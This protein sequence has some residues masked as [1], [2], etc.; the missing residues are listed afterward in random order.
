MNTVFYN[1]KI[2]ISK[3]C[4]AEALMIT[5]GTITA[6]GSSA[7]ILKMTKDGDAKYDCH[8]RTI[9]PGLN[10]SHLH[11]MQYA[12]T[13]NQANI[14]N[15]SS[16]DELIDVCRRFI[17]EHPDKVS[18]GLHAIGWNQDNFADSSRL[19]DRHDLDKISTD[20]PI[21]LE[22][23]C[24]HIASAN[25]CLINSLE[26]DKNSFRY[27]PGEVMRDESGFPTGIFRGGACVY[28]KEAVAD[29]T[30]EE[31]RA[32]L[33]DAMK[34]AASMGLTSL[35]SNDI[36]A[37]FDDTYEALAMLR[38]IYD[39][40]EAAVRYHFQMCFESPEAFSEFISS[41]EFTGNLYSEDSWITPGP[42][43]LYKDGSLGAR[44]ALMKDGY[45]ND[46]EN[47]G[48]RWLSCEEM[49]C[50]CSI[51]AKAGI[52]VVTHAIGSQ[53]IAETMASYRKAFIDGKNKLRH[54]I[55]HCQITDSELI[56]QIA[57]DD[58]LVMAQP[59]FIDYDMNI[60]E[61]LCGKDII[62]TSYAFGT[63]LRKG[64][65]LSY[66]TDCPVETCNPFLNIYEAVTRKDRNG[67]PE[68]GFYPDEAVDVET[69]I[70][71]YTAE[72]AYAQLQE[73]RKGRL[74]PGFYADLVILDRDIFT[75]D[76]AEIK[77]I[78][79]LLTMTGGRIVFSRDQE[80]PFNL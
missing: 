68:A 2:Y 47:K 59:V 35:Q 56:E 37:D 49:D 21:V 66:G 6:V 9:I 63:L 5:G 67:K 55:I 3:G 8:G 31:K 54:A 69:A 29:F 11:L 12:E 16:I 77:D 36:G 28:I 71:A 58:F 40:E 72:S 61:D 32:I 18:R 7:D 51:A 34:K 74:K 48:L 75:I 20:I 64:V 60:A 41:D 19:P 57:R 27:S 70:D 39:K 24:G 43:K 78:R 80:L 4:F 65:H 22:R 45:L 33:I 1:A 62:S 10:D 26:L 25:T 13:L 30:I 38:D 50:Y 44:T 73:N 76:P 79:P 52:Q 23:V 17:D 14:E 42:L 46:I 15:V 53:A